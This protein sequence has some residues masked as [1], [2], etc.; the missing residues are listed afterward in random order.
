MYNIRKGVDF[1]LAN[2]LRYN[3]AAFLMC[4]IPKDDG[5]IV[6]GTPEQAFGIIQDKSRKYKIDDNDKIDI[7]K[8]LNDSELKMSEH[9]VMNH[10][11]ISKS[12]LYD[13]K[14]WVKKNRNDLI[15]KY[16]NQINMFDMLQ[17]A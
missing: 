14:C 4:I 11:N 9:E 6:A 1:M 12:C 17:L 15:K 5:S 7:Y 3:I 8:L 16:D 2:D 10:Y 13:A